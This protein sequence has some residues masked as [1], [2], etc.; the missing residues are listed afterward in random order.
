MPDLTAPEIF[1]LKFNDSLCTCDVCGAD[2]ESFNEG[3]G[4]F[5]LCSD[6]NNF[7]GWF[8]A[9]RDSRR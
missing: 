5:V 4:E 9:W 6:H 3:K 2:V 8:R 7:K 1:K